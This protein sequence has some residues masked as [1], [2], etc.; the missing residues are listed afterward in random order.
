MKAYKAFI[1]LQ[2]PVFISPH[3]AWMPVLQ[4]AVQQQSDT[5]TWAISWF[6]KELQPFQKDTIPYFVIQKKKEKN[7]EA[8]GEY[9]C[10]L[11]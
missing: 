5:D 2:T 6:R 9:D 10:K 11:H 1:H 4:K 8:T 3:D 7:M